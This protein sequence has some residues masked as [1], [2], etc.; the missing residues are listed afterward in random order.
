MDLCVIRHAQSSNNTLVDQTYRVC[1]PDLTDLG[2]RQADLLARHLA[3]E[4]M[5]S[6]ILSPSATAPRRHNGHGALFDH[7][8]CSPMR[9]ALQT[10]APLGKALGLVPE[11]WADIHEQGGVWLDHGAGV[12][13]VGYPGITRRALLEE[14]PGYRVSDAITEEG[15]WVQGQEEEQEASVRAARVAAG[16]RDRWHHD[17]RIAFVTH[18][19]FSMLLFRALLGQPPDSEVCYHMDNT[20]VSLLRFRPNRTVS[21]RY[22]N[23]LDHLPAELIS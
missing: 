12:G 8:Y 23:R 7:L 21:V 4:A 18:G 1:D 6:L 11:V 19:A 17:E 2:W 9:R 13:T 22:M 20:G 16:L 5:R 10:A 14:F 15:W 3:S